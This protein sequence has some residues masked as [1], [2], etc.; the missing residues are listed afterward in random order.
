MV[1]K[2]GD[3][4]GDLRVATVCVNATDM[5]RAADFWSAALGYRRPERIGEQ[6][7]FAK[8]EDPAGTGPA[9]LLQRAEAIPA[10]PTPVHLD[11]YTSDRDTH[12][13]RLVKLGATRAEDW[14]YPEEHE[15]VVLRDTEGNEF[16]VINVN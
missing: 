14:S 8:L 3:G 7:Q 6:D 4:V 10:A 12:I 11:L 2:R 13:D 16:C 1:T 9:V 15:F 5:E